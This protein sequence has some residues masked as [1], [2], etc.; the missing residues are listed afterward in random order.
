MITKLK[1]LYLLMATSI[2]NTLAQ[3]WAKLPFLKSK[4][5]KSEP[6]VSDFR[7]TGSAAR[8]VFY[9]VDEDFLYTTCFGPDDVALLNIRNANNVVYIGEL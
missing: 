9:A 8:H 7:S 5:V 6:S 2:S 3:I 4:T 1:S